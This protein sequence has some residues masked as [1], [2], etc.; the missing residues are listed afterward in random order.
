MA[1]KKAAFLKIA[2][3]LEKMPASDL[4]AQIIPRKGL[5]GKIF[6]NKKLDLI[7]ELN[8]TKTFVAKNGRT[9]I[10]RGLQKFLVGS[11]ETAEG[12]INSDDRTMMAITGNSAYSNASLFVRKGTIIKYGGTN[13]AVG[14]FEPLV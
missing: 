13:Q 11:T 6:P 5:L 4:P 8:K 14:E 2:E 1:S 3:K 7:T 10:S 9:S 12:M